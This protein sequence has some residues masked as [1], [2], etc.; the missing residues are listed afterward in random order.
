MNKY[1]V[2]GELPSFSMLVMK[3]SDASPMLKHCA[4]HG[5]IIMIILCWRWSLN[6][7]WSLVY[8]SSFKS[9]PM[10][11]MLLSAEELEFLVIPY[12]HV[13]ENHL[14]FLTFVTHLSFNF[15]LLSSSNGSNPSSYRHHR[16]QSCP[17][18]W[19]IFHI[20]SF[21]SRT[22]YVLKEC[23]KLKFMELSFQRAIIRMKQVPN[24]RV[25][26]ILLRRCNLSKA[27]FRRVL[28]NVS[29]IS[30]CTIL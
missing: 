20:F 19:L 24:K 11:S 2:K 6:S 10:L 28:L 5:K 1:K 13:F 7:M 27:D 3:H 15:F 4:W 14:H 12:C 16:L 26:S 8:L 17:C 18:R 9:S 25:V 30:P 29:A 22:E 23:S 21:T